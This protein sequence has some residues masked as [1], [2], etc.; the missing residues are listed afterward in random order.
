MRS[1]QRAGKTLRYLACCLV[2]LALV[3]C[4][5]TGDRMETSTVYKG[6]ISLYL[7][8]PDRPSR[9]ITFDLSALVI[10]DDD[11]I[12]TEI[13][14]TSLK[15]NSIDMEGRQ[16]MLGTGTVPEGHYT[17]LR[18]VVTE[19]SLKNMDREASLALPPEGIETSIN[20]LIRRNKN[21]TLFLNWDAD[22][23]VEE[24]Y[25]F[26]PVFMAK[27]KSSE[28]GSL[29]I[30]VTNEDGDNVS[31]INRQRG[32]I[33]ATVMVGNKPRGI[34]VSQGKV[35]PKVYVANSGSGS[36]SV[37]DPTT[38]RVDNEIPIRFGSQPVDVAVAKVGPDRELIFVAN[39]GSD[40]V[41][42]VDAE[43]FQEI[44]RINVGRGPIAI[45]ADPPAETLVGSQFL[46]FEDESFL[47]SYRDRYLNV[48]VANY[49]AKNV[50]VIRI[51]RVGLKSEEV[52]TLNVEWRPIALDVDY[53]KGKVYVANYGS[54]K[55]SV[56][57]IIQLIKGNPAV[58]TIHNLG[59]GIVGVISDP[60]FDRI[61]LLKEMQGE[62]MI[63]RPFSEGFASLKTVMPPVMGV[64]SVGKSPRSFILDPESRKIYTVN[65][66][67]DTISVIDKTT[68]KEEQLIPVGRRPY[69]ITV[70]RR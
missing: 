12:T 57:D 68:K 7:N 44:E 64:V 61:Y 2:L 27:G 45:K 14:V 6:Q 31:V 55:V 1:D 49:D 59:T 62:I 42:M 46:S 26:K 67:S 8:G 15:I 37:I 17:S 35:R 25:L 41:S 66:G 32:E 53:R 70:F 13:P 56:I 4:A 18:F 21:T 11:G 19:A 10:T 24:G 58:S 9:D 60:A 16:I 29:L 65:R 33:V 51:D 3:S 20:I 39:Y 52:I 22:A 69:G 47:R 36:I 5:A 43:T 23:S 50:S 48:Y 30:Y 54:D 38:N 40:T 63:I 34:T 28:L